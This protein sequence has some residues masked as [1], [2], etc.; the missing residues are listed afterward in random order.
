M[1]QRKSASSRPCPGQGASCSWQG[2]SPRRPFPSRCHAP[3]S[4]VGPGRAD[5]GYR[6][7]RESFRPGLV[8]YRPVYLADPAR[9][10]ILPAWP[11]YLANQVSCRPEYHAAGFLPASVSC[12][13]ESLSRP[14][15]E[16]AQREERGAHGQ[17]YLARQ[18]IWRV[19]WHIASSISGGSRALLW[20]PFRAAETRRRAW[21]HARCPWRMP[22]HASWGRE[23]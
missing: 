11:A 21:R 19:T 8:S 12:R 20:S 10:G 2:S 16:L 23:S 15:R 1:Q 6:P 13:P 17:A 18:H 7:A 5:L 22:W 4:L 14:D 9:L 3:G